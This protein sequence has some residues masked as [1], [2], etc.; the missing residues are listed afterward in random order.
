V[1]QDGAHRATRGTLD[2][3]DGAPTQTDP[4]VRGVVR[5]A[6]ADMTGSL[7][8]ELTAQGEEQSEDACDKRWAVA[9]ERNV[10]RCI[11]ESDGDGA[12]VPRLA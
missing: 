10:G 9:Q 4:D 11:V 2:P 5:D 6:P 8:G 1:G 7:V 3:Q 12:I